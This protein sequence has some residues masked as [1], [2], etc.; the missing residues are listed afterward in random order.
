[1][2]THAYSHAQTMIDKPFDFPHVNS[3]AEFVPSPQAYERNG[4]PRGCLRDRYLDGHL[5]MFSVNAKVK[6]FPSC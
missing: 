6:L 1:M 4:A 3:Q 2:T 5:A